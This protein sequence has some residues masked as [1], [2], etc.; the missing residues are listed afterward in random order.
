MRHIFFIIFILFISSVATAQEQYQWVLTQLEQNSVSF[1]LL[2]HSK[3]AQEAAALSVPLLDNPVVDFGYYWGAPD[4]TG[5]RHDLSVQQQFD[6]PTAYRHRL[7]LRR[8]RQQASGL[9]YRLARMALRY[10][11]QQLCSDLVYYNRYIALYRQRMVNADG[12]ARLY[13][14]KLAAGECG[15]LDYNRAQTVLTTIQNNLLLAQTERDMLQDNLT[16]LNGGT[17]LSFMQD[18][19]ATASLPLCFETWYNE[20]KTNAA[21]L[22]QLD[23]QVDMQEQ[24][25]RL[26]S[27][28]RLPKL[29]VGYAD[30]ITVGSTFRGAT[31]GITLP[32]WNT[33]EA[34]AAQLQASVAKQSREVYERRCHTRLLGLYNKAT[35]LRQS[36]TNMQ[37]TR[38]QYNSDN[39]LLKA[40]TAGELSLEDYLQQEQFY[41]DYKL[42]LLETQ[43]ELDVILLQLYKICL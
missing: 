20:V 4:E 24:E 9:E 37:L 34:K 26:S 28:L 29:A 1:L 33:R 39:L 8:L 3:D 19:F 42:S 13:E 32:I 7:T 25:A 40:L 12:V 41:L 21:E 5:N 17:P 18:T 16:T 11:T 6:F 10:E 31:L 23:N 15:I 35:T 38:Q 36:L 22:Q 14:K 43:H 27:A 2:Q 30:E